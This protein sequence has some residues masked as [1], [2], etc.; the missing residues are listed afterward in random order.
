MKCCELTTTHLFL[1]TPVLLRLSV[2]RKV[3]SEGL[4]LSWSKKG[5]VWEKYLNYFLH[6]S[7]SNF[8]LFD[9]K[10]NLFSQRELFSLL[11]SLVSDLTLCI[12][13]LKI[14][15]L[16]SLCVLLWREGEKAAGCQYEGQ[17]RST[18][19]CDSKNLLIVAFH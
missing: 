5:W 1:I 11:Q 16:F 2:D 3:R 14:F 9:N 12:L 7:Q 6:F 17:W 13:T 15:H 4:K 8:I 18:H 10:V 19:H